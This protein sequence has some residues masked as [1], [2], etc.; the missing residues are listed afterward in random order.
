MSVFLPDLHVLTG[1]YAVDAIE[2]ETELDMFEHHLRRC[3]QCAC[4]VAGLRAA[5]TRLA[6]AAAMAP[7]P[8]MRARLLGAL[9]H[10][11]QLPPVIDRRRS[12][13]PRLNRTPLLLSVV[14]TAAVVA[15]IVLAFALAQTRSELALTRSRAAA[16]ATVLAAPDAHA[17]TQPVSVGGSATAVY[18]PSMHS[19]IVT[20]ASLP[21]PPAG[22]VYE[23]WL[24]GPT[25]TR[26]AGFLPASP[27]SRSAPVLVTGVQPGDHLGL[28]IEPVGGTPQ[29]TT[30]PVLVI[31]LHGG[32]DGP[33][34]PARQSATRGPGTHSRTPQAR[35][36]SPASRK[37]RHT[38]T[39]YPHH[40]PSPGPK[41][42]PSSGSGHTPSPG[43][44]HT[45]NPGPGHTPNPGPKHTQG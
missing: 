24:I 42:T 9:A 23:L 27:G 28:T 1:A 35:R 36:R 20:S 21:P 45:P 30:Q 29:P 40:T 37:H 6:F 39:P 44:G 12:L 2:S 14:A 15:V 38:P 3:Q 32:P 26:P 4:E 13:W 18:S 25:G 8:P 43:S 19:V 11:R 7:P 5:T 10:T 31:P 16:L 41:H 17:R 22:K 34:G 33:N